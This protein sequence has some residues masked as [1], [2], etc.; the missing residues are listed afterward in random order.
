MHWEH[1]FIVGVMVK[2]LDFSANIKGNV[3]VQKSLYPPCAPYLQE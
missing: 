2:F 1:F 3:D